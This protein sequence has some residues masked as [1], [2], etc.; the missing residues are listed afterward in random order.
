M[1][2]ESRLYSFL[3]TDGIS[4]MFELLIL[5]LKTLELSTITRFRQYILY[6]FNRCFNHSYVKFCKSKINT[7]SCHV[8][9]LLD[10]DLIRI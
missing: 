7:H 6:L 8:F 2:Q 4:I 5:H 9:H 10:I 1:M 3:L